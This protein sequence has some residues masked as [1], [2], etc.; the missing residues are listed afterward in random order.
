MTEKE[1]VDVSVSVV[2]YKDYVTP[3]AMIESLERNTDTSL[4]KTVYV[5]DNSS[6]KTCPDIQDAC[7]SFI[8]NISKYSDVI[9]IDAED[10]LGFGRANNLALQQAASTYHVFVNP[11]I[12]FVEDSLSALFCY[13]QNNSNV[14]MAIPRMV[15]ENGSMQFAYRQEVTVLDALNRTLLREKLKNRAAKHTMSEMDYSKPFPVPFGQ[16]S[17]LFGRTSLLKRLGGFDDRYF[18][19]LED[20]DL[21]K[22]V[23]QESVLM[24]TPC[25]TVIH[26]WERGSHKDIRLLIMHIKSYLSYF[27]KWGFRLA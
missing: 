6:P 9:Y 12:L 20:A 7:S 19:Y 14:G 3:L 15:E 8:F 25:T 16:G 22:R 17:F 27:R 1:Y 21:C 11:D 13:M 4:T 23:N 2:L 10:N 26:K 18:I 24:Y 5:V